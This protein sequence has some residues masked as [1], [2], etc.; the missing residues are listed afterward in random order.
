MTSGAVK[1]AG[2]AT[3]AGLVITL[4]LAVVAPLASHA[5]DVGATTAAS[6]TM[7]QSVTP[8]GGQPAQ[9]SGPVEPADAASL[10]AGAWDSSLSAAGYEQREYFASGTA[11]S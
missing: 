7:A 10:I 3:A 5:E 1:G 2:R 4:V 9:L 6:S 11:Y 8:E